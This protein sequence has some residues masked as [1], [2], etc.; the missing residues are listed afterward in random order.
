M[1]RAGEMKSRVN[2]HIG[3]TIIYVSLI[4]GRCKII[5][6]GTHELVGVFNSEATGPDIEDAIRATLYEKQKLSKS[7]VER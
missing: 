2:G 1:S 6:L 3:D 7:V 5:D 4:S